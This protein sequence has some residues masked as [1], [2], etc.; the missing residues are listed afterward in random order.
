MRALVSCHH[1]PLT[2]NDLDIYGENL[3]HCVMLFCV[4]IFR[5]IAKQPEKRGLTIGN[6]DG[7]HRGHRSLLKALRDRVGETGALGALTFS[8]HPSYVLKHLPPSPQLCSKSHKIKLLQ[9]AGVDVC[10]SIPFTEALAGLSYRDFLE[11]VRGVFSFDFLILGKGAAFGEKLEGDEGHIQALARE[12]KFEAIY[13]E[14]LEGRDGAISSARIRKALNEGALDL[15]AH[16]LGRPFS[17]LGELTSDGFLAF[18]GE[19]CLP[20]EGSYPVMVRSEEGSYRAKALLN[21]GVAI[22]DLPLPLHGEVE[23]LFDPL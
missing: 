8:T 16:M 22:A 4:R 5:E 6:F 18:E 7:V 17:V 3:N 10:F 12:W 11:E 19:L 1:H 21:E 2:F 15:A 13:L 9:E 14:K 23:V 20:P